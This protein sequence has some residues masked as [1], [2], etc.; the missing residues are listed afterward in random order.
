[1]VAVLLLGEK[2]G[3]GDGMNSLTGNLVPMDDQSAS[4][5]N[6]RPDQQYAL[7]DQFYSQMA[8][9]RRSYRMQMERR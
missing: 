6:V 3:I 2:V 1:V 9:D 8:H 7:L 4:I 5:L